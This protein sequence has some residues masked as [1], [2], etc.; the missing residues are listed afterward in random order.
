MEIFRQFLKYDLF[1]GIHTSRLLRLQD[2]F[3]H[4]LSVLGFKRQ[5]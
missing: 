2:L 5:Y 1:L 3:I 4:L